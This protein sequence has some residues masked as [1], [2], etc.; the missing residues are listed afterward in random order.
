MSHYE[1]TNRGR[2]G[3]M[4]TDRSC[5]YLIIANKMSKKIVLMFQNESTISRLKT[6]QVDATKAP[7][8]LVID[9]Y[10]EPKYITYGNYLQ[11][12]IP[13]DPVHFSVHFWAEL[14]YPRILKDLFDTLYLLEFL[15]VLST[16]AAQNLLNFSHGSINHNVFVLSHE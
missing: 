11:P 4:A 7:N 14:S 13:G 6:S 9:T 2:L 3:Y 5:H 8:N 15:F 16:Y 12:P 10:F 1:W